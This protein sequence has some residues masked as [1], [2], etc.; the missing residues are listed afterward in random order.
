MKMIRARTIV[1]AA[2]LLL[3]GQAFAD[4]TLDADASSVS[5]V[6]VKNAA[7]AEA[8]YFT[9]LSGKVT[10]AGEA[11]LSLD[12]S[13][14]ETLIPIRNERMVEHLFEPTRFPVASFTAEVPVRELSKMKRGSSTQHELDGT[15]ELHGASASV[16]ATVIII[17]VG[18]N[19]FAVAS[20]RPVIVSAGQFDLDG[21]LEK[22]REIAGLIS[23]AP[24]VPVSFSL[25]YRR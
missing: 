18:K 23:I 4:W 19:A 21:G 1:A 9:G 15:L 11:S 8:H 2:L 3:A 10:K 14:F 25:V 12:M 24:A 13:A 22:L 6:S 5:F 20:Q 7:I 16:S 17:R